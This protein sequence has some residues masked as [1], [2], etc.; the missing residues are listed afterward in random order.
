MK[1]WFLGIATLALTACTGPFIVQPGII[2]VFTGKIYNTGKSDIAL[3]LESQLVSKAPTNYRFQGSI[4]L[5]SEV[6]SMQG[7]ETALGLQYQNS[8]A[9]GRIVATLARGN[10]VQ[11]CLQLSLSY[12]NDQ[13]PKVVSGQ[14][15]QSDSSDLSE[16]SGTFV[17]SVDATRR[18]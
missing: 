1:P 13:A 4:A 5:E 9:Q 2:G 3:R 16:C 18:P 12:L 6:Y 7:Q 10:A 11:Y 14:L 15:K 17:G 8:P